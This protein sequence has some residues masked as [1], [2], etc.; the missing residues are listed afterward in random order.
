MFTF[1]F[2]NPDRKRGVDAR[3]FL[4]LSSIIYSPETEPANREITLLE[5]KLDAVLIEDVLYHKHRQLGIL[6]H[7]WDQD[8][9]TVEGEIGYGWI[10]NGS[11]LFWRRKG[12][13]VEAFTDVRRKCLG[14][15]YALPDFSEYIDYEI[16]MPTIAWFQ[17]SPVEQECLFSP[18]LLR[19]V[20]MDWI[21]THRQLYAE[22]AV[23]KLMED[24]REQPLTVDDS[25]KA[26][27][28]K[29]GTRS[30]AEKYGITGDS[31]QIG[32]LLDHTR[33]PEMLGQHDFRRVVITKFAG[34][35][36]GEAKVLR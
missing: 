7:R 17:R 28:C 35:L 16:T 26:G 20:R 8:P 18:H 9:R 19:K 2:A 22:Q 31:I 36:A 15:K 32:A 25:L 29:P 10:G 27:N 6:D 4:N 3:R 1:L 11:G 34:E 30:F 23:R 5:R 13:D 33:L 12:A 21:Y 14:E 24:H